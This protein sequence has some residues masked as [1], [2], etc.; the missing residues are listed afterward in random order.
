MLT[1]LQMILVKIEQF[2]GTDPTPTTAAN[3]LAVHNIRLN[4]NL[5]YIDP[6]AKDGSL[7]PRPGQLGQK[8]IELSFDHEIQVDNSAAAIPPMDP[9]L[10]ACAWDDNEKST[11]PGKYYAATARGLGCTR[12][13]FD[14]GA[15]AIAVGN[16]LIG[17]DS[18]ASGVVRAVTQQ[19]S[20]GWGGTTTG[21]VYID[22]ITRTVGL[23]AKTG[24]GTTTMTAGGTFTGTADTDYKAEIDAAGA[25]D[26]FK[27][28][29]DGGSTWAATGVSV[30]GAAQA[31]DLQ[32]C[33][34]EAAWDTAQGANVTCS[35][36][37]DSQEG[38][39]SAKM[40]MG[41]AATAGL[42]ATEAVTSV[43]ISATSK[44][45]FWIKCSIAVTAGQLQFVMDDT[46]LCAS[47]VHVLDVPALVAATWTE[48]TL[49]YNYALSGNSAII[50]IGIRQNEDLGACDI[51]IDDVRTTNGV[52][53]TFSADTGADL[54]DYWLF[55]ASNTYEDNENLQVSAATKAVM[56]GTQW[57]PSVTI[58]LYEEDILQK[59]VG[60]K[61][62]VKFNWASGQPAIASFS[63][64]GQYAKPSDSSLPAT[65]TDLG[66]EFLMAMG[67]TF[68]WGAE[69]PV[70]ESL[71]FGLNNTVNVLPSLADTHGV[72]SIEIVQRAPE[73]TFNPE[74]T[75]A[76]DID[77]LTPYEA[78]TQ[79]AISYSMTNGTVTCALSVPNAEIKT[80]NE[81]DRNG[82]AAYEIPCSCVR[83]DASVGDD[84]L[85]LQFS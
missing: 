27:W 66:D 35:A 32:L 46:A 74:V 7:S 20:P 25:P 24:T 59:I 12:L 70:I 69:N 84:E 72:S 18:G 14:A 26:T 8:Y 55:K 82:V 34:C 29:P 36:D 22:D 6:Q 1:E 10:Q 43:D 13:A 11:T 53:I 75:K 3:F 81:V 78:V 80:I 2:Y 54:G 61:G 37:V 68:A 9:L 16:T 76:S 73:I 48:V 39:N 58:W 71:N 77:Y 21:V 23:A 50:A 40:V 65:W 49:D 62:D 28:S 15:A 38:T 64:T 52:T 5:T 47:P 57:V 41:A 79:T 56:V 85:Y 31:L 63:M 17:E 19:A 44:V 30:T 83:S 42:L 67:G 4:R 60:C 45:K 51:Y 33:D